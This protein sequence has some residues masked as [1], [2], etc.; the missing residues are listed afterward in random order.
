MPV[1]LK[2][3]SL[4]AAPRGNPRTS[5]LLTVTEIRNSNVSTSGPIIQQG[6]Q[7]YFSKVRLDVVISW[8]IGL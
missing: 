4:I 5:C 2:P 1:A 6:N 7:P 8:V 3:I